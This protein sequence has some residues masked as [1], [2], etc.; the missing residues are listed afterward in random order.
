M[1][2]KE[3]CGTAVSKLTSMADPQVLGID[4]CEDGSPPCSSQTSLEWRNDSN[5]PSPPS[6]PGLLFCNSTFNDYD[7]TDTGM[8]TD[9]CSLV[10]ISRVIS[11]Y[12]VCIAL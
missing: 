11:A 4:D 9:G 2:R 10:K 5:P 12:N 3:K 7:I 6:S 1:Y 8:F